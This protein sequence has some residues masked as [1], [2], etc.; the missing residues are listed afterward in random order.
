MYARPRGSNSRI[1]G[2]A[3][4]QLGLEFRSVAAAGASSSWAPK[5]TVCCALR[6]IRHTLTPHPRTV[7]ARS[8][9]PGIH[10]I[11]LMWQ[12]VAHGLTTPSLESQIYASFMH[13]AP[14]SSSFRSGW[15]R[16]RVNSELIEM[17]NHDGVLY[18]GENNTQARR[19][20]ELAATPHMCHLSATCAAHDLPA[21]PNAL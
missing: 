6:L 3:A 17:Q 4:C 5:A 1:D 21:S 16:R 19:A 7:R 12:A 9:M 15:G 18:D 10:S 14:G 8:G 20:V 2:C 13:P 11:T